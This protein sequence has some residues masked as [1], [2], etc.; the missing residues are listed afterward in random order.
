MKFLNLTTINASGTSPK[1][2]CGAL[3]T[4]MFFGQL[5][6][7]E[8]K[9]DQ[10]LI[11]PYFNVPL[12]AL[13]PFSQE[14]KKFMLLEQ[15]LIN[16]AQSL[17]ALASDIATNAISQLVVSTSLIAKG[18]QQNELSDEALDW[19][20]QVRELVAVNLPAFTDK[21]C[22]EYSTGTSA[23]NSPFAES[24]SLEQ[25]IMLLCVDVLTAYQQVM[26]LNT[27]LDVQCQG[28][29]PGVM[30]AE[31]ASC[32]LCFPDN[33][34]VSLSEPMIHI[35]SANAQQPLSEQLS[36]LGFL[37]PNT[38]I[39]VGTL[40]QPWLKHWYAQTSRLFNKATNVDNEAH[41]QQNQAKQGISAATQNTANSAQSINSEAKQAEYDDDG[42]ELQ[43]L[44]LTRTLGYLGTANLSTAFTS[45]LA[46]LHSPMA[47]S[48]STWVVDYQVNQ[49]TTQLTNQAYKIS[50][51]AAQ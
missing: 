8:L 36:G 46:Y 27:I 44:E 30:P 39:H 11:A 48:E 19:E 5:A 28:S 14:A 43:V 32:C 21:L 24:D 18:A 31:A 1:A 25:P 12:P 38:V 33:Y 40:S 13:A 9:V 16:A 26:H 4:D 47:Q 2:L 7:N 34:P 37:L 23:N 15:C 20:Q 45:A 22:F 35:E 17:A 50:L 51:V 3:M 42:A 6:D 10:A 29:N 41:E 49:K